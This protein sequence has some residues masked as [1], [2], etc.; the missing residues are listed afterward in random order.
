MNRRRWKIAAANI[1]CKNCDGVI[2]T[3]SVHVGNVCLTCCMPFR[4]Y[5]G[6]SLDLGVTEEWLARYRTELA[7]AVIAVRTKRTRHDPA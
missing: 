5:R 3:G 7:R 2:V 6:V 4:M 1:K